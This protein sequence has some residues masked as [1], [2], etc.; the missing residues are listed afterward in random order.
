MQKYFSTL[1][2]EINPYLKLTE[3]YRKKWEESYAPHIVAGQLRH[4]IWNK[5]SIKRSP[6]LN[7]IY[8]KIK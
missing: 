4:D 3:G 7:I 2:S 8:W 1:N 5:K 6:P